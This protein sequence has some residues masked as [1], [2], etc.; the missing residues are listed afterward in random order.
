[1]TTKTKKKIRKIRAWAIMDE[2][3]KVMSIELGREEPKTF[4]IGTWMFYVQNKKQLC[5]CK[6]TLNP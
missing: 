6:I 5:R 3:G 1:M 4:T 2:R